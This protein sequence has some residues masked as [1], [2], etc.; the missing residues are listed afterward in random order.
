[1]VY[2]IAHEV[3]HH[4]QNEIG[5]MDDYASARQGKSKIE[6]NQLNVKL[7]SQADY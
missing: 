2:V 5:T 7:E 1:M 3:G 6:A 4:I